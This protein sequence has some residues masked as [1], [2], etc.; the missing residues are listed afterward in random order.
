M[1][2]LRRLACT[3]LLAV[4]AIPAAASAATKEPPALNDYVAE[5]KKVETSRKPVSLEPLFDASDNAAAAMMTL[6]G[7]DQ[8][9]IETLDEDAFQALRQRMRGMNLVRG[10]DIYTQ[11]DGA[12]FLKLAERH[13]RPA[14]IAF[15]KL[16]ADFWDAEQMPKYLSL[17]QRAT[18]CVRFDTGVVPELYTQWSA[19]AKQHPDAYTTF[20]Q[21]TLRDLE[22]V[23]ELGV[24]TCT[25]AEAVEKE[26]RG[27]VKRFPQSTV[28]P[29][30]KARLQELKDDPERRPVHCR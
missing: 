19:Y 7:G 14:D 30:V 18:P 6:V 3:L 4:F 2:S 16:Y 22:E 24:C 21:Q 1:L 12:W 13:G 27:F 10:Y 25:D 9:W 20:A 8:A 26:L 17:G 28:V 29:K 5:L 15:F 23:V 11:P